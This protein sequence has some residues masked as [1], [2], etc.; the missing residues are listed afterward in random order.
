VCVDLLL[1]GLVERHEAVQDV[2]A[3]SG[4]VGTAL[5][6]R[7]VILHRAHR[8]L[9]LEAID[10]V[11]EENDRRLH[12]PTRVANRVEQSESLLHTVDGLV[13]EEK[14]V[15]FGNSDK[16]KNGGHVLEAVNPLLTFRPLSTNI[17]HTVGK[18]ANDK[19]SLGDTSGLDTRAK[20]ILVAGEVVGLGNAFDGVKVAT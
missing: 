18:I 5:V 7:E 6:V 11:K 10:L 9:L 4:I 17:E 15:V 8:E 3:S 19:R 20:D 14:L 12:K 16:E 13:L 1:L 2:I